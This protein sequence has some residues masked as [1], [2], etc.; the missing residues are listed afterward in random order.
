MLKIMPSPIKHHYALNKNGDLVSIDK[1]TKDNKEKKYYCLSCGGEMT[2]VLG[3]IKEHHFRHVGDSCE[4]D[5]HKL[6]KK[7]IKYVFDRCDKFP[8]Y[9]YSKRKR[10]DR[11]DECRFMKYG[12]CNVDKEDYLREIDLKK[13]YD[14]CEEESGYKGFIADLKLSSK[15]NP[16]RVP[17]FIEIAVSHKCDEEKINSGVRII[18]LCPVSDRNFIELIV[19]SKEEQRTTGYTTYSIPQKKILFHNF[20]REHNVGPFPLEKFSLK[21][22]EQVLIYNVST[23]LN[24]YDEIE[25]PL[26]E[27]SIYELVM[28]KSILDIEFVGFSR[29]FNER[30]KNGKIRNCVFCRNYKI[31][32]EIKNRHYKACRLY[33]PNYK[34]GVKRDLNDGIEWEKNM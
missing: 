30:F 4:T 13:Y 29:A 7:I 26:E 34:M 6:G 12:E 14:T 20:H 16:K 21:K 23:N 31:C 33:S 11:A 5:L 2:A 25:L 27:D 18:E 32:K 8:V 24:C 28:H 9:F 15:Q 19:E 3:K 10:C 1:I 22:C 17:L